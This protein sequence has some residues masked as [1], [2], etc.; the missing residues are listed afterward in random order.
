MLYFIIYAHSFPFSSAIIP[1]CLAFSHRPSFSFVHSWCTL[2][3]VPI[4]IKFMR[5]NSNHRFLH[6][7]ER[8]FYPNLEERNIAVLEPHQ[9]D[10]R[11]FVVKRRAKVG[12]KDKLELNYR[13]GY[14]RLGRWKMSW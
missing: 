5:F 9:T 6:D 1:S 11:F 13:F 7:G 14:K 3:A 10:Y 12:P 4:A 2:I 8:P